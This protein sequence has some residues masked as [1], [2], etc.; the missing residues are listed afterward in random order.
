[1]S[2]A[3]QPSRAAFRACQLQNAV[4]DGLPINRN[5]FSS[6]R[7]ALALALISGL[8]KS[9]ELPFS[10]S[11]DRSNAKPGI[12]SMLGISLSVFVTR[13]AL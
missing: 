3:V 7:S 12:S 11:P 4:Q 6:S 1:M 9:H 8:V 5:G 13:G 10:S 2:C